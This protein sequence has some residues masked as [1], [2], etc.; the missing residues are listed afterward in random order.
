MSF[1][2]LTCELRTIAKLP[3]FQFTINVPFGSLCYHIIHFQ[4]NIHQE[5][6]IAQA[7]ATCKGLLYC[8]LKVMQR[9]HWYL[10]CNLFCCKIHFQHPAINNRKS[11]YLFQRNI[12]Q[13]HNKKYKITMALVTVKMTKTLWCYYLTSASHILATRIYH[14][15]LASQFHCLH[16]KQW[17]ITAS[18]NCCL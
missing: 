15:L 9:W 5:C 12:P 14:K 10:V 11:Y 6:C 13:K 4:Q 18:C 1:F 7:I 2:L 17:N 3:S 8:H 16:R